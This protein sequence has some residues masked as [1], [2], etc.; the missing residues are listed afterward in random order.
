MWIWSAFPVLVELTHR[1]DLRLPGCVFWGGSLSLLLVTN[2]G[3][4]NSCNSVPRSLL[5]QLFQHIFF[6]LF[7]IFFKAA[8]L[9]I[10]FQVIVINIKKSFGWFLVFLSKYWLSTCFPFSN[11]AAI[12]PMDFCKWLFWEPVK[13]KN[14]IVFLAMADAYLGT[15]ERISPSRTSAD[16]GMGNVVLINW[17]LC[18]MGVMFGHFDCIR[19]AVYQ[20]NHFFH[21]EKIKQSKRPCVF[22]GYWLIAS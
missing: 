17:G 15:T 1:W 14:K 9:S 16:S 8:I 10:V 6:F 2:S 13:K 7:P 22:S 11:V 20:H 12:V 3:H 18:S 4:G 21:P 19:T 5:V